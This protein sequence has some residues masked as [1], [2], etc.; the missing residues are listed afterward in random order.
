M[1]AKPGTAGPAQASASTTAPQQKQS[2]SYE[3]LMKAGATPGATTTPEAEQPKRSVLGK[4]GDFLAPSITRT[5]EHAIDPNKDVT[6]RDVI[7]SGL[8]A[9]SYLIPAGGIAK[10]VS[11]GTKAL[12]VVAR[13]LVKR[14]LQFGAAGA[15]SGGLQQAG[16]A[17]GEGADLTETATR[18]AGGAV[19]GGLVGAAIPLAV[20][21]VQKVASMP[22]ARAAKVAEETRVLASGAP[23][24][25]VA[26]KTLTEAG[27]VVNDKAAAE[28]VRQGIPEAD[29]AL[30][31]SGS[32]ADKR[33][34]LDMLTKREAQI[35]NKRAGIVDRATD[36]VGDTFL[37]KVV[38]PVQELNK[39]AA[40]RLNTV[41]RG[42]AGKKVDV[43]PAIQSLA[44]DFESVGIGVRKDGTLRFAGSAFE[45]RQLKSIQG[46]LSDLW[47]RAMKVARTG[48]A[49]Q[50]HRTKSY[51][52]NIVKYGAEGQGLS[53]KAS[54]ML[55]SFRHN[56]DS[57]LDSNFK[58]YDTVNTVYRDTIEQMNAMGVALGKRF[59]AGDAFA[60]SRAGLAMR[61]IMS[62]TQ[63]RS[64]I[65]KLIDGMQK[66]AQ[67]YGIKIDED[68]ITQA[69]FADTLENMFG[70]EAPTSFLGQGARAMSQAGQAGADIAQGT[71]AGMAKGVIKAGKFVFDVTRGV[72]EKRKIE[73]LK[74]LLESGI[75][76]KSTNFGRKP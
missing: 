51:I 20:R 8:E 14:A 65:L 59:K 9:A 25:S 16:A 41:A 32:D 61:R 57:I 60:D 1:G 15:V 27:D 10:G 63:S 38:K 34:M 39:K 11:L 12:G 44:S 18:A 28:V 40:D 21:G 50:L 37:Q 43:E 17:V 71:P 45:G 2:Y 56:I 7:G 5:I 54:A 47:T 52:D 22:G 55:K 24:A 66:V 36:V 69:G 23:E 30:I 72:N 49:L 31:K 42:L 70:S 64:D 6:A 76:K 3:E 53:G 58:Q 67:K 46:A 19:T 48:D 33:K 68:V 35:T 13:P 75:G 26:T 29:V 4:V 73:A 62:N 74:V